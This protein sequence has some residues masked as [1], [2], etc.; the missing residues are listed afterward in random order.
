MAP[1]DLKKNNQENAQAP[2]KKTVACPTCRKPAEYSAS[3]IYRPF[4]SNRCQLID[5]GEWAEGKYAIAAEPASGSNESPS[6]S[7]SDE[8]SSEVSD[9]TSGEMSDET[10]DE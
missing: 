4:C 2:A 7:E 10:S 9:E 5:L 8:A 6:D 3:N 1:D